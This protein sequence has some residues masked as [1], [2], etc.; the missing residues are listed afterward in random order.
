[1]S[2]SSSFYPEL[3]IGSEVEVSNDPNAASTQWRLGRVT[4]LKNNSCDVQVVT[5]TG[6]EYRHDLYHV[7]DPRT[8]TT[9]DWADPSRGLFRL[10]HGELERRNVAKTIQDFRQGVLTRISKNELETSAALDQMRKDI[11]KWELF[12]AE[13]TSKKT[14]IEK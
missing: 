11:A 4:V 2:V 14:S 6:I 7:D 13:K 8:Y 1:M 10:S 12:M 3:H 5:Q 9:K